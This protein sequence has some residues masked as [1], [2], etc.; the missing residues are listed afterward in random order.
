MGTWLSS[1]YRWSTVDNW[2]DDPFPVLDRAV[3]EDEILRR[4]LRSFGPGTEVDIKWW[5]GWPVTRVRNSLAR[6]GA[7]EV[8]LDDDVGYVL[9]DDL[10]VV[11]LDGRRVQLLPSLDP[12]TMGWKQ[13]D[14]YLGD[15]GDRLFDR[16]GNAGPTIWADGRVVG[17]WTQREDGEIA[18]EIL[19]DIGRETTDLVESAAEDLRDWIGDINVT[20]RFRSPHD[21]EL[22]S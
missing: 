7:V 13:R 10:E 1:Q 22:A 17:G 11:D 2:L 19:A 15:L 16:N 8:G 18:Y 14:W 6:V 20:A 4:W 21:K 3:A 9:E 5:T 12:T